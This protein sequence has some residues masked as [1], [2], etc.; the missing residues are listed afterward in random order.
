[1]W[2]QGLLGL[3]PWQ[4]ALITFIL[5]HITILSVTIYLH[6]HSAH[7]AVDLHP[8]LAHFFRFW[9]WLTTGMVTKEWTAI[10]RKHHAKCETAEDPPSPVVLGLN[11][12]LFE[13]A[14]LYRIAATPE[15]LSRYGHR[16]PDDWVERKVY[17]NWRSTGLFLMLVIDIALFG[18]LGITVWAVQM[19]W[20]PLF[21]AGVINGLGHFMGYRNFECPDN[22]RNLVPWGILVGGEELH[23]NHH[24]YPNSAKLS[25]KP[26]EFDMGWAWIRV[27][28]ALKLAKVKSTGPIAHRVPGKSVLDV[29]TVLAIANN[30]F[31]IMAEYQR[32]VLMPVLRREKEQVKAGPE[33][34][35]YRRA[36][37]LMAREESLIKPSDRQRLEEI[38]ANNAVLRTIH[39]KSLEL[40]AIWKRSPGSQY[41]DK[42]N[43]LMEWCKQAEASG[44]H[45]LQEFAET[46]K[47]YSLKPAHA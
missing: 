5:T 34:S 28:S 39:E 38:L 4:I 14:E 44:I 31:R 45:Y 41:Q 33:K 26:W 11:R 16:T 24:T 1:M 47:S 42:L 3:G 18:V 36:R 27:F 25:A 21:A 40:Q 37:T 2:Y 9:L 8:V 6:R 13:G 29:D 12:V 46:L 43:A 7:N 32:K 19:L 10:H 20:I 17:S 30:R 35:L 22:A 15:T 23:N